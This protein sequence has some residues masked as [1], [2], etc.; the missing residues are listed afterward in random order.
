MA[1][2][3]FKRASDLFLGTE[4]ELALALG[5]SAD[6]LRRYRRDPEAELDDVLDRLATT[7]IDRGRGMVRVGE[8]LRAH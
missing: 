6:Q 8:L 3:D 7:L 2:L 5:I 4:H 1:G